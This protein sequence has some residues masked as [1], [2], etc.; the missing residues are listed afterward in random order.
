[1]ANIYN[2]NRMCSVGE[3]GTT[4]YFEWILIFLKLIMQNGPLEL[5]SGF[6]LYSLS[7]EW[8]NPILNISNASRWKN[9]WK[10]SNNM[11]WFFFNYNSQITSPFIKLSHMNCEWVYL[12]QP[13]VINLQWKWDRKC[14][15][16]AWRI[17]EYFN[18]EL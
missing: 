3:F 4:F 17:F 9:I 8:I 12:L 10:G 6:S 15:Y 7:I 14:V 16:T 2:W 5:I 1:M 11:Y 13:Q 18:T